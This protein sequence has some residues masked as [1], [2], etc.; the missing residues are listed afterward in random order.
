MLMPVR[1]SWRPSKLL[2]YPIPLIA[3]RLSCAPSVFNADLRGRGDVSFLDSLYAAANTL[4]ESKNSWAPT[5][6][7][8]LPTKVGAIDHWARIDPPR[9][10]ELVDKIKVWRDVA[11]HRI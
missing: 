4:W 1:E 6:L 2:P 5:C 10:L 3:E 9:A 8:L 7:G 11:M